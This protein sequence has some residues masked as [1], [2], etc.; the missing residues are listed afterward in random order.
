MKTDPIKIG[1][2]GSEL[3]L[4]QA[5]FVRAELERAFPDREF[6]QVIIKTTGDRDQKS[7]LTKIGGRGVFTKTIE[8]A[9]SAGE[10]DIAVH[11][12]K[13]LPSR[14]APG[15]AIAAAPRRGPAND[16]LV[17]ESGAALE[18]LPQNAQIATGSIRRRSQL[19]A[20]RPDL[21]MHDLRGNIHTRLQKLQANDWHGVIMAQAALQ[22]LRLEDVKYSVLP[23]ETMI[24]A[25]SQGA[26]GVQA[27][28]DDQETQQL[29]KSINDEPTFTAVTAE[30]AVLR[31]LDSGCQF[32]VGAHARFLDATT[33]E[34]LGFVSDMAGTKI[35][36][37]AVTGPA[38]SAWELGCQLAQR[39]V[40]RG[41]HE[42]L[43]PLYD[44]SNIG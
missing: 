4:W 17:T 2:R 28:S 12:L 42:L 38:E 25:V 16:V 44:D 34:I 31:I 22:R 3:A 39:L 43:K 20:R 10:I 23:I 40:D 13:D 35:L 6:E 29:V 5:N 32:P 37:Q 15:L 19:L 41:A 11:S 26:I 36:R 24:P 1:T 27:R 14:E 18:A 9:L 33:L 8:E 7:S 30:R 21:R